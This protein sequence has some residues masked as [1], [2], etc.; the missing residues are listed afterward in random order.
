MG[1]GTISDGGGDNIHRGDVKE[2]GAGDLGLVSRA[3]QL[4]V[5]VLQPA[6]LQTFWTWMLTG[7]KPC[8]GRSPAAIVKGVKHQDRGPTAR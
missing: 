6:G 1:G 8:F 5:N 3:R 4:P 2:G 7:L